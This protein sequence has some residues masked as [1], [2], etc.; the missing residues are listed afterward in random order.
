MWLAIKPH[1]NESQNMRA[2]LELASKSIGVVIMVFSL[3]QWMTF[4]YPDTNPFWHGAIWQKGIE[5][6][7]INLIF[8]SVLSV[9]G[10]GLF[11]LGKFGLDK[12]S[13]K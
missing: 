12:F 1:S 5:T 7:T 9:V 2:T 13:N 8:V 4:D 6:G 11:T 3:F 10:Y